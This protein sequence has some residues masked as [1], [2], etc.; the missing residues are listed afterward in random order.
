MSCQSC[1]SNKNINS[2]TYYNNSSN[3]IINIKQ[4]IQIG[5]NDGKSFDNLNYFIKKI[6]RKAY[7]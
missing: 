2:N 7:L 1:I 4:L 5:A 3:K 6:I